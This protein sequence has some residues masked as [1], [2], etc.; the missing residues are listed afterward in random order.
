MITGVGAVAVLVRDAKKSAAWYHEKLGFE[1]VSAVDH[2]VFVRPANSSFPL[3][4]LCEECDSWE[5]DRPGGNTGIW[6]PSGPITFRKAKSGEFLPASDPD[7]VEKTCQELKEK[8]V[9][10][11]HELK[12]TSWG[13]MASILDLDGNELEIS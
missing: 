12:T 10:F 8:G 3:L 9:R 13:K 4:H 2:A 5:A 11:A 1:I 7:E 6:L